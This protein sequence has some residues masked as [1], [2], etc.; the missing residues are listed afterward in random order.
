LV[1]DGGPKPA[2]AA[3]GEDGLQVAFEEARAFWRFFR[4]WLWRWRT[5]NVSERGADTLLHKK[6]SRVTILCPRYSSSR[7]IVAILDKHLRLATAKAN[8][9]KNLQNARALF[10]SHLQSVFTQRGKGWLRTTIAT[11]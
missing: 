10:E 4:R 1:A 2:F 8:A 6:A 9:E 7:R 11:N 3:L 5:S